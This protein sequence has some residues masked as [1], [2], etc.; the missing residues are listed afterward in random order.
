MDEIAALSQEIEFHEKFRGYDPDEVEVYVDRVRKTAALA[1]GRISELHQR[2][3]AAEALIAA[4]RVDSAE[5]TLGRVLLLA[6]Q[7]ADDLVAEAGVEAA[8]LTAEASEHAVAVVAAADESSATAVERA[9]AEAESILREANE[10]SSRVIAEAETDRR[11][12][13]RRM[14]SEV[15]SA[16]AEARR[17]LET[18]VSGLSI[19]RGFLEDDIE[20]LQRHVREQRA[21]LSMIVSSLTDL[22]EQPDS[23]RIEPAPATSGV[24]VD[25]AGEVRPEPAI[26]EA[27]NQP[28]LDTDAPVPTVA[29]GVEETDA[30]ASKLS[31]PELEPSLVEEPV[32]ALHT[33]SF[34]A[35]IDLDRMAPCDPS[36]E[37][38]ETELLS[39]TPP[40]LTTAADLDSEAGSGAPV[41]PGPATAPVPAVAAEPLFADAAVGDGS[42]HFVVQ[43]SGLAEGDLLADDNDALSAFFDQDDDDVDRSWFGRRR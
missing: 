37:V 1:L 32:P 30:V 24:A 35:V 31:E 7:T 34:A 29:D 26:D 23:F 14:E 2:V 19:T 16:E 27:S 13:V 18:D 4:G 20:I 39:P 33:G 38:A 15:A 21:N 43:M 41:D 3:E 28:G 10:R 11:E 9:R 42:G 8:R 36:P 25:P 40:R 12:A 17:R 6:Q 5:E 22:I